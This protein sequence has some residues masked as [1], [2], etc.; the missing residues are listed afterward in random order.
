MELFQSVFNVHR[1]FLFG[2]HHAWYV[3]ICV[4]MCVNTYVYIVIRQ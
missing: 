2:L 1:L 3:G 4:Y